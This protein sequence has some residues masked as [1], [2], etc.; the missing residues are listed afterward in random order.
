MNAYFAGKS[1]MKR[2]AQITGSML[3]FAKSAHFQAENLELSSRV[4]IKSVL[5]ICFLFPSLFQ[6]IHP[7]GK[8][9]VL[10]LG[11]PF[12]G[13]GTQ[14]RMVPSGSSSSGMKTDD[15]ILTL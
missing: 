13:R 15:H 1:L 14:A 4:K 5:K 6:G 10:R 2:Q 7:L 9:S 11:K 8:G 12:Q 3:C